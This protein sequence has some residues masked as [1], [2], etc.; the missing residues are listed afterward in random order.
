MLTCSFVVG[1][2][3]IEMVW[4][5]LYPVVVTCFSYL[6]MDLLEFE[7][8]TIQYNRTLHD[9]CCENF[10][11]YKLYSLFKIRQ[12][13]N[14]T[15]L[16]NDGNGKPNTILQKLKEHKIHNIT[17]CAPPPHTHN[18]RSLKPH[19]YHNNFSYNFQASSFHPLAI[20]WPRQPARMQI[21]LI[22]E[23]IFL[24]PHVHKM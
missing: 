5:F 1:A 13:N 19:K 12:M 22:Y 15:I 20:N 7:I 3:C 9:H 21:L 16:H 24:C 18:K 8:N 10:K 6:Y 4:L 23:N 11:S 17:G 14:N 2:F